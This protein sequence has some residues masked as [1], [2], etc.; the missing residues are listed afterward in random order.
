[1]LKALKK[2][3]TGEE[4]QTDVDRLLRETHELK[5]RLESTA[6]QLDRYVARDEDRKSST[7]PWVEIRGSTVDPVKGIQIELD[8]NDA[9]IQYLKDNNFTGRDDETIVQKWLAA[10]NERVG[11]ALGKQAEDNSDMPRHSEFV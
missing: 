5:D 1:M 10:L 4:Q 8:W 9:F 3:F 2:L 6:A 7:E 11:A